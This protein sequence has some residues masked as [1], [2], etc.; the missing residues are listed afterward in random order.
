MD[1]VGLLGHPADLLIQISIHPT[2][3]A[4]IIASRINFPR[5]E[6]FQLIPFC[7]MDLGQHSASSGQFEPEV[8]AER[9]RR[10]GERGKRQAGV[11]FVQQAI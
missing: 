11:G 1:P 3:I 2:R 7:R 6:Y 9:S 8:L 10:A 4:R 5:L